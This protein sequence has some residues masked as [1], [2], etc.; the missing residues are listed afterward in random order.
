[1]LFRDL[2][3]SGALWGSPLS[4]VPGGPDGDDVMLSF[5]HDNGDGT[6][7]EQVVWSRARRA[8]SR[9][10]RDGVPAV[11]SPSLRDVLYGHFM[12]DEDV[13]DALAFFGDLGLWADAAAV[14]ES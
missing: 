6:T 9:W 5:S 11:W 10:P 13:V 3:A 1:M 12:A 4:D 7:L 2:R 14:M 8:W